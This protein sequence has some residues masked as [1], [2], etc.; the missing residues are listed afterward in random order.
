MLSVS[1]FFIIGL[2]VGGSATLIIMAIRKRSKSR[3]Y[4]GGPYRH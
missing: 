3:M 2:T 1:L 4:S